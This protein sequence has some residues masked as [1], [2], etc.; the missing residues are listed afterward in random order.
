LKNGKFPDGIDGKWFNHSEDLLLTFADRLIHIDAYVYHDDMYSI[1]FIY[2]QNKSIEHRLRNLTRLNQPILSSLDFE[3]R[4]IQEI[5]QCYKNN[6]GSTRLVGL[7]F[8][9]KDKSSVLLGSCHEQIYLED[10]FSNHI[11]GYALGKVAQY[12][13]GF[14]FIWYKICPL[15]NRVILCA[16]HDP[17]ILPLDAFYK[18]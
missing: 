18:D 17:Y 10:K 6:N 13:T 2:S 11:F 16:N 8:A 1:K 9:F 4:D 5:T 7:F 3:K 12:L 15:H 14:Q